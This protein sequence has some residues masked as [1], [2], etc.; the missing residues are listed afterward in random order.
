MSVKRISADLWYRIKN[1]GDIPS[2]ALLVYPERI[3]ENILRMIKTS[4]KV[5]LLRPHVKTHK[6]PEIINMQMKHG[7]KKFKCA[8]IAEAEMAASA[9]AIDVLLAYQPVGPNIDRF[10]RLFEVFGE[11]KFSCLADSVE[12][13]NQLATA[14]E[15]KHSV[16]PVWLDINVGMNRTGVDPGKDALFLF[17]RI[18][19]S[20]FLTAEGLHVYDGHIHD[21]DLSERKKK[22]DEAFSKVTLLRKEIRKQFNSPFGIV[23][24]GSPTFPVHARRGDVETSP[25]TIILWDYGYSSAF[26]DMDFLHAAVLMTRIISKPGKDLICLDL[27]HKAIASEMGQPRIMLFGLENYQIIGHN[28]E[29]MV[30]FTPEAWNFAVGDVLYGIPWH[31]CPTVDRYDFVDAVIDGKASV[32][33]NVSARKRKITI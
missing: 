10:L 4:G 24:G 12:I 25:G 7:I 9:G 11:T 19:E 29:H 20:P 17:K 14:A 28:E 22:C 15:R 13:V 8:T 30:I 6:M 1:D 21:K 3:E 31:I 26:A 27:G 2:P 5:D 23:A 16:V 33:W 32:R 18:I